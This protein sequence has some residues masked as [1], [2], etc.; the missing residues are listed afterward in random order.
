MFRIP[1]DLT[2]CLTVV[3]VPQCRGIELVQGLDDAA[4]EHLRIV[5]E[6]LATIPAPDDATIG[7]ITSTDTCTRTHASKMTPQHLDGRNKRGTR[8][9]GVGGP[10]KKGLH[11]NKMADRGLSASEL[12]ELIVDSLKESSSQPLKNTFDRNDLGQMY[13]VEYIAAQLVKKLGHRRWVTMSTA[14]SVFYY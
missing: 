4:N 10:S 6:I 3:R 14:F 13:T 9:R 8:G 7:A 12:E 1:C 2:I 11:A 5:G